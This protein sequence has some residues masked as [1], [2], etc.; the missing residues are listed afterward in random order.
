MRVRDQKHAGPEETPDERISNYQL[1]LPQV[2][3]ETPPQTPVETLPIAAAAGENFVPPADVLKEPVTQVPEPIVL[4]VETKPANQPPTIVSLISVPSSPQESGIIVAWTAEAS[5]LEGDSMQF[6]FLVD[7]L[8]VTDWQLPNQWTMDTSAYTVGIHSVETKVRDS[9]HNPEGD[10]SKKSSFT[11]T[12]PNELPVITEFAPDKASPQEAGAIVTWTAKATDAENDPIVFR[13]FLNGLPVTDWQP[14][15]KWTWTASEGEAQVEVQ[16]RDGKHAGAEGF[17]D[18]SSKTFVIN[19]PNQKPAIINFGP[20]KLGPQEAGSTIVWTA[21]A[22]DAENDP[23]LYRFFLNGQP[24]SKWLSQGQWAWKTSDANLGDNEVEVRIIDGNHADQN[25]FDDSKSMEFTIDAPT[26]EEKLAPLIVPVIVAPAKL[27]DSPIISSLTADKDSPQLLGEVITWTAEANDPESDPV[28]YRFLVN[29]TLATDWQAQNQWSWTALEP[30]ISQI[31]VQVKD[32]QHAGPQGEKGNKSAKFT[33]K[34]PAPE[35]KPLEIVPVIVAPAKLNDS[36]IISSLTAD[37]DSPQLVGEVITWTAEASDPESDPV[38][39]RFLVNNTLATDW[40]AQNQWSWTAL[41]PGT[42]QI[43]VQVKDNQHA[44]PQ[45]EK[46]NKSAKFTIKAPA[47]EIKPLEI[48]PVIVA[49][50]KLNDSPII[51]S[52]TADKDSPQLVGEVITWT[53]EASDPESDPV[54]YRFLVNNTLAT[55]WQAQNQ[56]SWTALEPGTSQI[57]VQVKDNQHAGPQG[58]KGNKS[59]KFT[60][61]APAPEIKPVEV[62]TEANV[63]IPM[64][65]KTETVVIAPETVTPPATENI[66]T[67]IAPE[68]VT[69]IEPLANETKIAA[70]VPVAENQTPI[71]NSLSPDVTSPQRPGTTI[72]WNANATDVD[73]DPLLFRFFLNGPATGG[74]WEPKT[75]W[76]TAKTWTWMTIIRGYRRKS[77][78]SPGEGWKARVRGWL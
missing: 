53:A 25:G 62:T 15:N 70:P 16:V 6:Q 41:E 8:P 33:I 75:D 10:D 56:W 73:Q 42:S 28:S 20:D 26:P 37:K 69:K 2:I 51:S 64:E 65:N 32:N 46:G 71:M 55:D 22:S 12:R 77:V 5:D 45:G 72:T 61:K 52:L 11:I 9:T 18:S 35:I 48:V 63:T 54:S 43:N 14:N 1:I 3:V 23:L 57:N 66:T 17:D 68:N 78:Q 4:P 59:A 21:E 27:N 40:Q 58:E 47:P 29:N 36:P 34:A 76:S 50:A 49:P 13:F 31:N 44:G 19:A 38:S 7:D 74:A 30:G 24:A 67:P 39:Y 60:I